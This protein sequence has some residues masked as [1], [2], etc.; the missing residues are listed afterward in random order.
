[1]QAP[2]SSQSSSHTSDG[3]SAPG[4]KS[5]RRLVTIVG[6]LV[7]LFGTFAAIVQPPRAEPLRESSVTSLD[8]WLNPIE[9]NAIQ[10]LAVSKGP[11]N[12]VF[13]LRGT[14]EVW[15]AGEGGLVIH[16]TDAGLTWQSTNLAATPQVVRVRPSAKTALG[17]EQ[18]R[19]LG[20]GR[21]SA[22]VRARLGTTPVSFV[23][24]TQAQAQQ[25]YQQQ[26][27]P[28]ETVVPNVVAM[29][30]LTARDML[31]KSGLRSTVS[32][33]V[34]VTRMIPGRVVSQT[35]ASGTSVARN[36][37]VQLAVAGESGP[38][39]SRVDSSAPP[40][41]DS[42]VTPP[43]AAAGMFYP[44]FTAI[45]FTSAGTGW[46][47]GNR[48]AVFRTTD[49]GATWTQITTD[50][51]AELND[52]ACNATMGAVVVGEA[53][54]LVRPD[55]A[56]AEIR[57]TSSRR[58][59]VTIL[60]GGTL[61][62]IDVIAGAE[63]GVFTSADTGR[64]WQSDRGLAGHS[65]G[66]IVFADSLNGVSM[67]MGPG[68][69]V[70]TDGG[71]TWQRATGCTF[72]TVTG[73]PRVGLRNLVASSP[74]IAIVLDAHDR[75]W[76]TTDRWT[77]CT[78]LGAFHPFTVRLAAASNE[79]WYA[80]AD[81]GFRSDDGG[82][83]WESLI[84]VSR[85]SSVQFRDSLHGMAGLENGL[86]ARTSNGGRSWSYA[87]LDSMDTAA[88]VHIVSRTDQEIF[89]TTDAARF[90]SADG[91]A[92]WASYITAD[93]VAPIFY[94][95]RQTAWGIGG[96]SLYGTRDGGQTWTRGNP[97]GV[98]GGLTQAR[99]LDLRS[100]SFLR[101]R[102][103]ASQVWVTT[104]KK[105]LVRFNG[106]RWDTLSTGVLAA[107]PV[108]PSFAYGLDTLGNLIRSMDGGRQW[109][110]VPVNSPR[111][112]PA[113]WYYGFV[114][115]TVGGTL[116]T[117]RARRR[118]DADVED[119][120]ADILVSDRP[121]REGDRDV[122]DFGRIAAGLSRFI[123]NSR[124]EPPLTIAI[125]GPWG[126]G[127]SSLMNL[128]RRDLER[129][130]FRTIWFNAWHHQRE[131]SLLASL[132]ES[133]RMTA[134]P[135][136]WTPKG[137][138]FRFRL[139]GKRI[140]RYSVPALALLPVFALALGYILKDPSRR[141]H[142]L[143]AVF[144]SFFN[145]FSSGEGG[146]VAR[147]AADST[148]AARG[149]TDVSQNKTIIA[150]AISIVGTV[151]TYFKGLKAFGVKP[152][153]VAKSVVSA[154]RVR[155]IESQPAFR[156]R[157]A[158]DF[159]EVTEALKPERI[160]IFID[161]LD[162]CKPEQ[163]LEILEAINFLAESGDCVVVLGIDRERVTGCVAIGFK[164]VAT[165]LSATRDRTTAAS[166]KPDIGILPVAQAE[167][168]T[169]I[170]YQIEY[171]EHYLEKLLNMEI[172]IPPATAEGL[173]DVMTNTA[174]ARDENDATDVEYDGGE[175]R[176]ARR[177]RARRYLYTWVAAA[178][179]IG[180][181]LA[182]WNGS[183]W[184]ERMT[185]SEVVPATVVA[186]RDVATTD[187]AA[188]VATRDTVSRRD[189]AAV[190][191]GLNPIP[192]VAGTAPTTAWWMHGLLT[193]VAL[194]VLFWLLTPREDNRVEDSAAFAAALRAWAPVLFE[195]HRT[196]R[197]AKKFL[198]KMRFLSMAQ[199]APA[200]RQAPVER[201]IARLSGSPWLRKFLSA[202]ERR[203]DTQE[204]LLPGSIPEV[205]LVSLNV[206]RDRQPAW[207]DDPAFWT[208]D[209]RKY[210][211]ARLKPVP[212]D[213]EKALGALSHITTPE[214]GA[215]E[216]FRW[217]QAPWERL[218]VWIRD[219]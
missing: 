198:N 151:L 81:G 119:S 57:T 38:P 158:Q 122:L 120:I 10:R 47:V 55:A 41:P 26:A 85:L 154:G 83:T 148:A 133:I 197:S 191:S 206:I 30:Y 45:C 95:D 135:P 19:R 194:G 5:P 111:K 175:A 96:D 195:Q 214:G 94:V 188:G 144:S 165:V 75:L 215:L 163:V 53:V 216:N 35:P 192:L 104:S 93:S 65:A 145:L 77:T 113:P 102:N 49:R 200:E 32:R 63:G 157:F 126:T 138:R 67:E 99:D 12:A 98:L 51:Q 199:R 143:D 167:R 21:Q 27:K 134:T 162:R 110:A 132:L 4:G 219:P 184:V 115:L 155:T 61:T 54:L 46:V 141:W 203:A 31:S 9:R 90:R 71:R 189:T 34:S 69:N 11:L 17:K 29:P 3:S 137:I 159:S 100:V 170:Q 16:S 87:R 182:G 150:L 73:A 136:V 52:I 179:T 171:A 208:T 217:C 36:T 60:G 74:D 204:V 118:K 129:R 72:G 213:I 66:P 190:T 128:L 44:D 121:L 78:P 64:T 59:S 79:R 183:S 177:R 124:T 207:L 174:P 15:F 82:R 218:E 123:R 105:S 86:V 70:T 88:P 37:V 7:L 112:Y 18:V 50:T 62:A 156:Y 185:Q 130:R 168:K 40:K 173:G 172:P 8:W 178:L 2:D 56:K 91:G 161:D 205:A 20:S 131:E 28:P 187:T 181:F 108:T 23:S 101:D 68:M 139:L 193:L 125:T 48:G 160:V 153:E 147:V 202:F 164:E 76:K 212:P 114:A 107:S 22:T 33:Y 166:M 117:S 13:A 116:A 201:A 210:V 146:S 24:A 6:A 103:G 42:V 89:V 169:D 186:A 180:M 152:G 176:E 84:H 127:K 58:R 25:Q 211:E 1:M 106:T 14:D 92:T 43:D 209:L 80:A 140:A 196:P 109:S 97:T 142:D 39:P 149:S